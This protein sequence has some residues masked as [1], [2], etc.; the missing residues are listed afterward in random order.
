MLFSKAFPNTFRK[1]FLHIPVVLCTY[2]YYIN[3]HIVL[4]LF[5][6]NF[7]TQGNNLNF[8]WFTITF[9]NYQCLANN[10]YSMFVEMNKWAT[11]SLSNFK[12]FTSLIFYLDLAS[13]YVGMWEP[14]LISPLWFTLLVSPA[15]PVSYPFV[16]NH[17]VQKQ[18]TG[19]CCEDSD[20][21][22]HPTSKQLQ[23]PLLEI[24]CL[25]FKYLM[26]SE[27]ENEGY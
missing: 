8:L 1:L 7:P 11:I 26:K 24:T 17:C 14:R 23:T 6:C 22:T 25:C 4:S 2:V 15:P 20:R 19:Q 21:V 9:Q 16:S 10:R 12:T 27:C 18:Q 13:S 3:L 5:L